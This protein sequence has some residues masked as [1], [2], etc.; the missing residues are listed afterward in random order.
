M[1]ADPPIR[2]DGLCACGCGRLVRIKR[3]A[4][5]PIELYRD[6]FATTE[7]CKAYHGVTVKT[8]S[9][10]YGRNEAKGRRRA[11]AA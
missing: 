1:I 2:A 9:E 10:S 11:V 3:N 7:C 6:P 4:K 5:V 8:Y